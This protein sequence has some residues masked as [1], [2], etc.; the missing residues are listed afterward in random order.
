MFQLKSNELIFVKNG[1]VRHLPLSGMENISYI[2]KKLLLPLIFG[3]ILTPL[4]ILA[5]KDNSLSPGVLL[6]TLFAALFLLHIGWSGSDAFIVK[7]SKSHEETL[8][9]KTIPDHISKFI[10]FV[11][12]FIGQQNKDRSGPVFYHTL[13]NHTKGESDD[14][15]KPSNIGY[16]LLTR[17]EFDLISPRPKFKTLVIDPLKLS[18]PIRLKNYDNQTTYFVVEIINNESIVE[19][20]Q[21]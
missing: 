5:I 12:L 6:P 8:F 19:T 2:H 7:M 13:K 11:N 1:K 9:F 16:I 20:I 18:V 15:S 21:P 4:I 10:V 17:E 14:V 3:G